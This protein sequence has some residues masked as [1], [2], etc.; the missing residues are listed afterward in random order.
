MNDQELKQKFFFL[1]VGQKCTS[2]DN[3]YDNIPFD[4]YTLISILEYW[5][6]HQD[7]IC[8]LLKDLKN[9]TD[10]H[11]QQLMRTPSENF[12]SAKDFLIFYIA[13]DF[14][15]QQEVDTLRSLGYLVPFMNMSVKEL[16]EKGWAKYIKS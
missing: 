1:Y 7:K 4:G 11:A 6:R 5:S 3:K 14:M 15:T 10:E 9:L 8:L 12:K 2:T 13:T 16:L